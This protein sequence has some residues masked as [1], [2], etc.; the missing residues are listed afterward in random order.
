MN[1]LVLLLLAL[2]GCT[3]AEHLVSEGS[4]LALHAPEP[5][6]PWR[7]EVRTTHALENGT[8]IADVRIGAGPVAE[9][10]SKVAIGYVGVTEDGV[11]FVTSVGKSEPFSF[12]LG[13]HTVNGIWEQ[14]IDGM[15]MG[16][17]R[18]IW[19]PPKLINEGR[20]R[21]PAIPGG[22]TLIFDVELLEV[23]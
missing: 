4:T 14:G 9:K 19:V 7:A 18:R 23:R 10:G 16:G 15:R 8:E 21:P 22:V 1:R 5:A 12:V 13:D 11:E 6:V 17:V 2:V 20:G 3:P